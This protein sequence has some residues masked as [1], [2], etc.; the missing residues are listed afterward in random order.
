MVPTTFDDLKHIVNNVRPTGKERQLQSDG[1]DNPIV[2]NGLTKE[3]I[4]QK[5]KENENL[6]VCGLHFWHRQTPES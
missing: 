2:A 6:M 3:M 4:I 5:L 1:A